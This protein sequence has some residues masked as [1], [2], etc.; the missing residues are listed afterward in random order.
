MDKELLRVVI[1]ATGL[2][3]IM[4]MLVWHF[5]KNKKFSQDMGFFADQDYAG[6]INEPL[7]VDDDFD[8]SDDFDVK[9]VAKSAGQLSGN[10]D[11][12]FE[13]YDETAEPPPRFVV[14]D[15]I[16]FSVIS[17][18]A[19]GFN[20]LELL[21]AFQ[22]A[23]L[24][25]GNLKIFER[26]D[27]N[28]LVDFGVACMIEPGTFPSSGLEGFHCPGVV[29]FMQPGVLED[30]RKVFDDFL[31][32]VN[33]LVMELDGEVLDHDRK[34]LTVATIQLIRQSL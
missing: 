15:I 20:G 32:A 7:V 18:S 21:K 30:A 1:I 31:E 22:I 5:L 26:L 9:P 4:G 14:P 2:L 12:D 17:K 23:Q 24:E 8:G 16:Q 10:V 13:F 3:V 34:P 27:A 6:N 11:S 33:S 25:Y 29:F 19:E 28:R